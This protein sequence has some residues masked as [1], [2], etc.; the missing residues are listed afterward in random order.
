MGPSD[1]SFNLVKSILGKLDR[2]IDQVREQR[3]GNGP[4]PQTIA[5][6]AG[7]AGANALDQQIGRAEPVSNRPASPFG[8]ATPMPPRG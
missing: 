1:R 8:R 3:I 6:P 4:V 2:S 5:Q 7:L